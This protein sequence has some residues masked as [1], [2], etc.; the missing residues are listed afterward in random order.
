MTKVNFL[1]ENLGASQLSYCLIK[2]GNELV[3]GGYSVV[4]FYDKITKHVLRP[5]FPTMQMVEGWAQEGMTIATSIP[6]AA[7]LLDFPGPQHKLFY[8][9]DL[10]WMRE[11][12]RMWGPLSDLFTHP[13]LKLIVRNKEYSK[14]VENAFNRTP[15]YIM[16]NF[17][18]ETM[19]EIITNVYA[20]K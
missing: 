6:S 13:S 12:Q 8:V 1:V 19:K 18:V 15:E 9:W 10:E 17:D 20:R 3:S 7:D 5:S 16:D 14:A 11:P 4:A 2:S